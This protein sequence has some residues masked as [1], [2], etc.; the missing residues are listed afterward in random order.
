MVRTWNRLKFRWV[1]YWYYIEMKW[2]DDKNSKSN[3]IDKLRLRNNWSGR[4]VSF[5]SSFV[6]LTIPKSPDFTV[7]VRVYDFCN[8]SYGSTCNKI[9]NTNS[10]STSNVQGLRKNQ[11]DFH[12]NA[13]KWKYIC[14]CSISLHSLAAR[15]I[16]IVFILNTHRTFTAMHCECIMMLCCNWMNTV[17]SNILTGLLV[18][19]GKQFSSTFLRT[20]IHLFKI[21]D[22]CIHFFKVWPVAHTFFIVSMI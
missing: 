11:F 22:I 16:A 19:K 15:L 4:S 5:A 3:L 6:S 17:D 2:I 10:V 14:I 21:T 7:R 1:N 13:R 20:T 12:P 8:F 9:P 18:Y